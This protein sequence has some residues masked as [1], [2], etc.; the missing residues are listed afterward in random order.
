MV[1]QKVEFRP[2][3]ARANIRAMVRG[4]YA[5]Q[6]LRIQMGNRIVANFKAKLG[7]EPSEKEGTLDK[8]GATLLKDLRASYKLLTDGVVT[9]PRKANFKGDELISSWTE[10]CLIAQY[11]ELRV[12]EESHFRRLGK[13]LEEHAIWNEFLLDVR[14]VGPAMAGVLI[15]EIDIHKAR[16]PSS[17]WKYAGLDVAGDGRGRSRKTEHLVEVE[18]EAADGTQKK[19]NSI[20]FNPF[21]KTKLTGVLAGSFV[22]S[23]AK[24]DSK[25]EKIYRD[26]KHRLENMPEHE[27]KSKGHRDNM[28]KRYMIKMFLVDLY[29]KWR[30]IEGLPIAAPYSEGKLG[31]KHRAEA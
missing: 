7:L 21:L 19:R 16:Y 24:G 9:F 23:G 20:T 22:R 17:L 3:Q 12:V 13:A 18:Y 27:E 8:E 5:V 1:I 14:G 10:L 2:E 15:S 6:E 31:I 28:A 4:A 29:T 25:Y 30:A 26:Y 11:V